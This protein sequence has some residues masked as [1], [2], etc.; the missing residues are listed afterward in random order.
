MSSRCITYIVNNI[1]LPV[2]ASS[3]EAFSVAKRKLGLVGINAKI[4]DF[5]IFRRSIDARKKNDIK[6]V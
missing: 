3:K 2:H 5:T 1:A 6:F 4:D